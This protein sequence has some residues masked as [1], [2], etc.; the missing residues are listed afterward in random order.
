MSQ[1][2][3]EHPTRAIISSSQY[4]VV[5]YVKRADEEPPIIYSGQGSTVIIFDS[6]EPGIQEAVMAAIEKS[7]NERRANL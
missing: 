1:M 3:T 5:V 2:A 7:A 4:S 6:C